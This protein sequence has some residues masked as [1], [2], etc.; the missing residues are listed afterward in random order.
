MIGVTTD[1]KIGRNAAKSIGI[2]AETTAATI[3]GKIVEMTTGKTAMGHTAT[4]AD[5]E[6]TVETM[7]GMATTAEMTG[8]DMEITGTTRMNSAGIATGWIE[9][10]KTREIVVA[11]IPTIPAI[12]AVATRRTVKVSAEDIWKVTGNTAAIMAAGN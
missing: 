11:P 12:S 3:V 2:I 6:L 5:T 1:G 8:T 4:M 7:A 10:R 9:V